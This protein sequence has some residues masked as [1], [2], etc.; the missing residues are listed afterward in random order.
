MLHN[1]IT[2]KNK[3]VADSILNFTRHIRLWNV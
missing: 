1:V 3:V 2:K